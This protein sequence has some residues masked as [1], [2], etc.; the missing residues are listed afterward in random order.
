[1][2]TTLDIAVGVTSIY[3]MTG[4]SLERFIAVKFPLKYKINTEKSYL[5]LVPTWCIGFIVSAAR[6]GAR[7]MQAIQCYIMVVFMLVYV[8]PL[9]CIAGA[10]VILGST[11][12]R[13]RSCSVGSHSSLLSAT[14][15]R[16]IAIT[17]ASFMVGW[18]PFMI[19][20]VMG[21][22]QCHVPIWVG[23][24]VKGIH[25]TNSIVNFFVYATKI[26]EFRLAV[27]SL[28]CRTKQ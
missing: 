9:V 1:M 8:I 19:L 10:Y 16:T 6:Y 4:I 27:I 17:I 28:I 11:L 21:V 24:V 2:Y 5:L 13:Q 23:F 7:S 18:T 14:V 12:K 20:N 3:T 15:S 26:H 25:Y 22:F